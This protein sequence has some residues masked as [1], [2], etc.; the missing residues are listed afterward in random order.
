MQLS[1]G[2]PMVILWVSYGMIPIFS[3][4]CRTSTS[5][6]SPSGRFF[7]LNFSLKILHMSEKSS[8]FAAAKV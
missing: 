5:S 7:L 8:K 6:P 3:L 1:Y 4:F 2:Y